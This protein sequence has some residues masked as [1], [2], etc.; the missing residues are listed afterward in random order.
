MNAPSRCLRISAND[1]STWATGKSRTPTSPV[2]DVAQPYR[3]SWYCQPPAS[4]GTGSASVTSAAA[5]GPDKRQG[6][7]H[8]KQRRPHC[9]D[10]PLA[11]SEVPG[12]YSETNRKQR[13]F[14]ACSLSLF[15]I[16]RHRQTPW[17]G[18]D[19]A[20]GLADMLGQHSA[21]ELRTLTDRAAFG[22][23]GRCGRPHR[24]RW[25]SRRQAG[26]HHGAVGQSRAGP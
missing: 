3:V 16:P 13:N 14:C 6:Y 17:R 19:W 20:T 18:D 11:T 8:S 15:G 2:S 24:R 23:P 7:H 9:S 4:I 12:R 26:R 10:P 1:T 25:K 21:I 22:Q 5:T